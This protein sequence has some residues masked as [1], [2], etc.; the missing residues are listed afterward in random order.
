MCCRHTRRKKVG[1]G[2]IPLTRFD[3]DGCIE[4]ESSGAMLA[5]D[6]IFQE[7]GLIMFGVAL[8]ARASRD[9]QRPAAV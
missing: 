6:L 5:V 8:K 4:H 3:H 7:Y 2:N 1:W 9:A